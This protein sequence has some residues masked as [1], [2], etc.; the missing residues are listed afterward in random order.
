MYLTS[1]LRVVNESKVSR[2]FISSDGSVLVLVHFGEPGVVAIASEV[3]VRAR[4]CEGIEPG[5]E[6]SGGEL[7][8]VV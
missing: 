3:K 6:F 2:K 7:A 4:S 1:S 8:V 5:S